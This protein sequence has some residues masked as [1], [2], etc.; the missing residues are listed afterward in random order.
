MGKNGTTVGTTLL[1]CVP[2]GM[3]GNQLCVHYMLS[4]EQTHHCHACQRIRSLAALMI[5][6]RQNLTRLAVLISAFGFLHL[7]SY[8]IFRLGIN[9]HPWGYLR[10]F[11]FSH[12]CKVIFLSSI[13]SCESF[14]TAA[15]RLWNTLTRH[16]GQFP[17]IS[18]LIKT[19][20][21]ETAQQTKLYLPRRQ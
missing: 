17:T 8:L 2:Q 3:M 16:G 13:C 5:P 20:R 19:R 11:F 14:Y 15:T 12:D 7:M 18:S 6:G 9:L 21:S 1:N 4:S 10:W